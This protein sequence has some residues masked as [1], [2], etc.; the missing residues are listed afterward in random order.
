M[1][2]NTKRIISAP[3][4]R[5]LRNSAKVADARQGD[6]N[7]PIKELIHPISTQ[8]DRTTN[9]DPFTQLEIRNRLMRLGHNRFLPGDLRQL[10]HP[11]FQYLGI[12]YSISQSH[13]DNN[14]LQLWNLHDIGVS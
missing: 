8:R 4:K 6:I 5:I 7:K 1:L 10:T 12:L 14:F 11:G 3:I 9:G 2:A 13:V